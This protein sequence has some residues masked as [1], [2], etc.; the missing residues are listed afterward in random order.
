MERGFAVPARSVARIILVAAALIGTAEAAPKKREARELYD[1]GLAA[2]GKNDYAGAAK[3]LSKSFALEEDKDTLF[4]WAQAEKKNTN[5]EKAIHLYEKVLVFELKAPARKAVGVQIEECR[6]AMLQTTPPAEEN[7][8]ATPAPAP[9]SDAAP[10]A[11]PEAMPA[12]PEPVHTDDPPSRWKSPLGLTLVGVG[13]VGVGVGTVFLLQ[14]K[15]A[16]SDQ[17][18]AATYGEWKDLRDKAKSRGTIGLVST[19]VGAA[20][21]VGGII[22]I[23]TRKTESASQASVWVTPDGGGVFATGRF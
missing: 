4:A 2:Y 22:Y 14:A 17:D 5:C 21:L 23:A 19:G 15:K 20:C 16:D 12:A 3:A 7:T 13:V 8:V 1:K 9:V 10:A 6:A 18:S 11:P